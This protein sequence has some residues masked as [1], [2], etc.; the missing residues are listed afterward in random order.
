[1]FGILAANTPW[2]HEEKLLHDSSDTWMQK[3]P[4]ISCRRIIGVGSLVDE[5]DLAD[6]ILDPVSNIC[7]SGPLST[8]GAGE[9]IE[10][11]NNALGSSFEQVSEAGV[12]LG[13]LG[14]TYEYRE[15]K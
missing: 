3:C 13:N 2:F 1:M 9:L 5:V 7:G 8:V 10:A 4:S 12:P 14:G 15:V 11:W 6:Q